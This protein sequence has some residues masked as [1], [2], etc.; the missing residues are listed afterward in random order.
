[1]A[2]SLTKPLAMSL[3]ALTESALPNSSF[4]VQRTADFTVPWLALTCGLNAIVTILISGRILYYARLAQLSGTPPGP[5]TN[6]VAILVESALPFT[7]LGILCAVYFG[8]QEAPELAFAIVWGAFVVS[9]VQFWMKKIWIQPDSTKS[10]SPQLIILRVAMG[11]AWTKETPTRLGLVA[12]TM[13]FA[14]R[15]EA[16]TETQIKYGKSE[17][18]SKYTESDL[19]R[20]ATV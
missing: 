7:I 13:Q 4:F 11:C 14:Q 3:L 16:G 9:K 12:S 18:E 2:C 8:K 5:H 19:G 10:L 17:S 20:E 15:S 1:M 6:I